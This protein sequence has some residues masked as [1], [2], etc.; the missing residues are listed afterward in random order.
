MKKEDLNFGNVVELRNGKL[1][2]LEPS[3]NNP[4]NYTFKQYLEKQSWNSVIKLINIKDSV[5]EVNLAMY[6]D[7]LLL[8][9]DSSHSIIR[10]Y[11]DYTLKELLWDRNSKILLTYEEREWI[12]KAIEHNNLSV[13]WIAKGKKYLK[14]NYNC[15]EFKIY[16]RK[17][18]LENLELNKKY[19][20]EELGL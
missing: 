18:K 14:V 8:N 4:N 19:T 17:I 15:I 1:C 10:V 9:P 3:D 16:M 20:P 2:L 7:D 6:A 11:K 5:Y 13:N 12:K